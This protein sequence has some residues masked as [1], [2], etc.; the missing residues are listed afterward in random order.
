MI[1]P[2]KPTIENLLLFKN[3]CWGRSKQRTKAGIMVPEATSG[4]TSITS[5]V[6]F[7]TPDKRKKKCLNFQSWNQIVLFLKTMRHAHFHL[8]PFLILE[9]SKLLLGCLFAFI[10]WKPLP[11][12]FLK[13]EMKEILYIVHC[14]FFLHRPLPYLVCACES[15]HCKL[16]WY[17]LIPFKVWQ[18][19]N[20]STVKDLFK[21]L[22]SI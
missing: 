15:K 7:H 11:R 17:N 10:K 19:L 13:I 3:T 9:Q 5:L 8:F 1:V 6:I 20:N 2:E 22:T 4:I 16:A 21:V 14:C 18:C 12:P